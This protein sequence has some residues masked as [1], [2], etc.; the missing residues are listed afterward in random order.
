MNRITFLLINMALAFFNTGLIWVIE[1][2]IFP[3]WKLMDLS[4][5]NRVRAA[6]WK[7]IPFL[8]FIPVGLAFI[9]SVILFWYHPSKS[10]RWAIWGSFL[11]QF[12]SHILTAVFWGRWQANISPILGPGDPLL[13]KI[14][15][16]HWIRTALITGYALIFLVWTVIVCNG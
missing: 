8:V 3:R 10:P 9:D 11:C 15:K 16:T 7:I 2:D 1:A 5:F 13:D 14:I 12:L 4:S 6:H